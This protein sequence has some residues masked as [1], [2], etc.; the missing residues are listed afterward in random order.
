MTPF[1]PLQPLERGTNLIE[2]SAGTGKTW[3]ITM[4]PPYTKNGTCATENILHGRRV[5]W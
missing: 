5:G 1:N 4:A 3:T 2:A